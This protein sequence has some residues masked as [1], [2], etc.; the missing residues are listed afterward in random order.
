M[1]E[2]LD[3]ALHIFIAV[4]IGF[5]IVTFVAQRTIVY[6]QSMEPTL[7]DR[8]QLVI[9]K[10][11]PRLGKLKHGDIVTVYVPEYLGEG[12]DYIIKRVIGIEGDTVEIKEGKVFV[13]GTELKEPY[14]NG[15]YTDEGHYGS[16]KVEKGQVYVLGDNRLPGRSKDSRAIGAVDVKRIRGRAIFRFYP[17]SKI[18]LLN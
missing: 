8:D 17:F 6:G 4:L 12:R 3:W 15:D 10:I 2:I 9:E 13:N 16:V 5:L 18:G 11:S 14:I 1:H 7:Q